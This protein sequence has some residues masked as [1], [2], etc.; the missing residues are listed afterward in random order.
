MVGVAATI[1]DHTINALLFRTLGDE[2]AHLACNGD[3]AILGDSSKCLDGSLGF[4]FLSSWEH[5]FDLSSRFA[6]LASCPLLWLSAL[7]RSLDSSLLRRGFF[8]DSGLSQ[9]SRGG[10]C[11]NLKVAQSFIQ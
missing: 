1:K 6:S 7:G 2:L 5:G 8:Y 4:T 3:F 10:F 11:C 9:F